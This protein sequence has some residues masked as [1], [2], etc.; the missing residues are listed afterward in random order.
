MW[1]QFH[2][3]HKSAVYT[4]ASFRLAVIP[5]H[6]SF[7]DEAIGRMNETIVF[8]DGN[9]AI[10]VEICYRRHRRKIFIW[11]HQRFHIQI[12]TICMLAREWQSYKLQV[13]AL[14]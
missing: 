10:A 9:R 7:I 4:R 13:R 11:V 14:L 3:S 8:I 5:S 1:I 6:K 2:K 12:S